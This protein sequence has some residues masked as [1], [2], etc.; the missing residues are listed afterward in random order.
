MSLPRSRSRG[1]G[2]R[3]LMLPRWPHLGLQPWPR[4]GAMGRPGPA[5]RS[6]SSP[7]FSGPCP[8]SLL[9]PSLGREVGGVGQHTRKGGRAGAQV[10]SSTA[11]GVQRGLRRSSP[12][13][14]H[15]R[16]CR[17][18]HRR[19]ADPGR[20]ARPRPPRSTPPS[21]SGAPRRSSLRGPIVGCSSRTRPRGSVRPGKRCLCRSLPRPLS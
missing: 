15:T 1:A 9:R 6:S 8:F 3:Y 13:K 18:R 4:G 16:R 5:P 10:S 7:A 2:R 11:A 19:R 14:R 12:Q 17:C 20:P 21:T